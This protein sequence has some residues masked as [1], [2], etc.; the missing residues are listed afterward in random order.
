MSLHPQF[1][2]GQSGR[3]KPMSCY[4]TAEIFSQGIYKPTQAGR[5]Q[6]RVQ[7]FMHHELHGLET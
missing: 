1:I 3:Q 7:A 6:A 4:M 2:I 5:T